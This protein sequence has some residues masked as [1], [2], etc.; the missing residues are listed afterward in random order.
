MT[1]AILK[2]TDYVYHFDFMP[3]LRLTENKRKAQSTNYM[4][5]HS[6]STESREMWGW[7]FKLK[8]IPH[9]EG[10]V[11]LEWTVYFESWNKAYDPDNLALAF[12]PIVDALRDVSVIKDDSG[13]FISHISYSVDVDKRKPD[14]TMLR[15]IVKE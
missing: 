4:S 5:Y 13:K 12:K 11:D 14:R 10:K 1:D 2:S 8:H 9:F 6:M 7:L 3:D 15:I